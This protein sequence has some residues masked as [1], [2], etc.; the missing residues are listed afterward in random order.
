[1][2]HSSVPSTNRWRRGW[3][4]T[5]VLPDHASYPIQEGDLLYAS[6]GVVYPA[7][8]QADQGTEAANQVLFAANFV[9]VAMAKDGLQTNET[10]ARITTR[11]GELL[12]GTTG[13]WEFPCAAYA[14]KTGQL[15]GVTEQSN[16]TTLE[17]QKVVVV[18]TEDKAIGIAVVPPGAIGTTMTKVH[19]RLRSQ[20]LREDVG[21]GQ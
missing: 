10:S 6:S 13:D 20:L 12:I 18:T 19:V 16:G 11:T 14:W 15:V 21:S 9:G 1:M 8:A 5:V 7:S 2:A 3:V 4:D 17:D